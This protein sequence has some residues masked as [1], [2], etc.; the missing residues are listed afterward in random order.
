M[1][2]FTAVEGCLAASA[3]ARHGEV[4]IG[5]GELFCEKDDLAGVM[6]E[7]TD[8]LLDRDQDGRV[9]PRAV[10]LRVDDFEQPL[11]RN[12]G[13]H[14]AGLSERSGEPGACIRSGRRR[15]E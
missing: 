5:A 7:V 6:V 12:I 8:D 2:Y 15:S 11:G 14:R 4:E 1:L 10:R 9:T 3:F 13:N